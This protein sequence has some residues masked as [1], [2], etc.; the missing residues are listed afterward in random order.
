MGFSQDVRY[1]PGQ[2]CWDCPTKVAI[3]TS[4]IVRAK[5][6]PPGPHFNVVFG[7]TFPRYSLNIVWGEAGGGGGGIHRRVGL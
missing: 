7:E 2:N 1:N 6:P 3:F 5:I 4:P